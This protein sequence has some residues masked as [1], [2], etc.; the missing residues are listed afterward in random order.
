MSFLLGGML[1]GGAVAAGAA[2]AGHGIA[3]LTPAGRAARQMRKQ[4]TKDA[5]SMMTRGK[6]HG[7]GYTP[8]KKR[9]LVAREMQAAQTAAAPLRDDAM[10]QAA[11]QGAGRGGAMDSARSL[12]AREQAQMGAETAA[13]VRAESQQVGQQRQAT[14]RNLFAQAQGLNYDT[15]MQTGKILQP[16]AEAGINR[17]A[18]VA[19]SELDSKEDAALKAALG[20]TKAGAGGLGSMTP[21]QAAALAAFLGAG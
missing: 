12:M 14:A 20:Q 7:W 21:E 10:R 16:I 11:A 15:Q 1:L 4:M 2:G 5:Q 13:R 6:R 18:E 17:M 3:A 19:A 9:E 8:Q